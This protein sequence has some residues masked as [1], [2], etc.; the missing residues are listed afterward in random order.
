MI[1]F[2]ILEMTAASRTGKRRTARTMPATA[3]SCIKSDHR[4]AP[5]FSCFRRKRALFFVIS[6][7]SLVRRREKMSF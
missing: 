7:Q 2:K 3:A 5:A 1:S 4:F 6:A